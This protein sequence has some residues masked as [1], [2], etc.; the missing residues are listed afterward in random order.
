MNGPEQKQRRLLPKPLSGD[1]EKQR[2]VD[3]PEEMFR[4]PTLPL[5]RLG[6]QMALKR[7]GMVK[8]E[9]LNDHPE[10]LPAAQ[11]PIIVGHPVA[12][13]EQQADKVASTLAGIAPFPELR[14]KLNV[15]MGNHPHTAPAIVHKV[16]ASPGQP[17]SPTLKHGM[18]TS[19][20]GNFDHVRIHTDEIAA[21]SARAVDALAYTVGNH[22]VFDRGVY[23]PHTEMGRYTLAHELAH[24]AQNQ[25]YTL[26][27][28]GPNQRV[29]LC[30]APIAR[31]HLGQMGSVHAVLNIQGTHGTVH[32]EV[33][34]DRHGGVIDPAAASQG[35]GRAGG[36]HSH[37]VFG[38]GATRRG[39]CHALTPSPGGCRHRSGPAL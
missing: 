2:R 27:R 5:S 16:I 35:P 30:F 6:N 26:R 33:N 25:P 14:R 38:S 23:A 10:E 24:V 32:A 22:I 19:L 8:E 18:E 3:C 4:H 12:E 15:P 20:E 36:L 28:F 9:D 11:K 39:S 29:E 7:P 17:L 34:P 31:F 1:Y 37:V 21:A 13:E